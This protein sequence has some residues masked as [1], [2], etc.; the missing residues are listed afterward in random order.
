[1]PKSVAS[2]SLVDAEVERLFQ[3]ISCRKG[4]ICRNP[5][6]QGDFVFGSDPIAAQKRK[7][8][9]ALFAR[10]WFA[11]YGPPDAPP[12]P[13]S[14]EERELMRGRGDLLAYI[15]ALYA[16][17]LEDAC[18]SQAPGYEVEKHPSFEQFAAGALWEEAYN[19]GILFPDDDPNQLSRLR[20]RFP[21]T[22][23]EGLGPGYYWTKPAK[24]KRVA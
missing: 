2:K 12:L 13:L 9:A 18:F 5:I 10:E 4:E 14:N 8:R 6:T 21:P 20:H 24:S 22:K 23:L 7:A 11:F 17:S 16:R 3:A 1:M 15:V 19:N